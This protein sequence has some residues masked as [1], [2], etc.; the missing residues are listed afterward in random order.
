[1]DTFGLRR[2]ANVWF[3]QRRE[4]VSRCR[5]NEATEFLGETGYVESSRVF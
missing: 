1:M 4:A 5:V 3:L 2:F